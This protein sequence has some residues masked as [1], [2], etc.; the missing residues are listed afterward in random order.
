MCKKRQKASLELKIKI[1][2]ILK[3]NG[4]APQAEEIN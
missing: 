1:T 4:W 2:K 3:L